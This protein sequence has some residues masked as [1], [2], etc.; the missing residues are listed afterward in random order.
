MNLRKVLCAGVLFA[1]LAGTTYADLQNVDVG[2][3]LRIRARYWNNTYVNGPAGP[4]EI[5]IPDFFVPRRP[6]GPFGVSSRYDWSSDEPD[7]QIVEQ[8]T[9]LDVDADFTNEVR[10]FIELE[11]YDW[12]GEEFRSD[13]VTGSDA[14]AAT[15]NDVEIYQAYIEASEMFGN[16]IRLRIGRQE[17]KLGKGWLVDDITTAIIGRSFDAIRITYSTDVVVVDAWYSKYVERGIAEQDGDV[18]FMGVYATCSA[19]E[20]LN[21]SLYWMWLRDG[22]SLNDTNV[23]AP[24]EWLEDLFNLDDYD[25]TNMYTVG[26]RLWGEAGALDYDLELAYQFGDAD[27]VGFGFK[28]VGRIYGDDGAEYDAWAADLEFGYI[29][30]MAWQPRVFIGGAYFE[31]Q[32]NRDLSFVDWINPFYRPE[33]SVSFNRMFPGKPY[34]LVLEIG[35]DMSNFYQVRTGVSVHPS[36]AVTAGLTVAYY[37]V[38]EPFDAPVSFAAGGFKIPLA[39]ALSFWTDESDDAIG[40]SAHGWIQYDYSED[41]YIKVGWE[42]LFTG[43]GLEDGSFSHLYGL[44][45]SGGRGD[46]DAD[47]V[48][49]DTGLKF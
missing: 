17:L 2:G 49:V 4:S 20:Y 13:Y 18:D 14:R 9:R 31:G 35:Q 16:P 1:A 30:D 36:E 47:Y 10:A 22:G 27:A 6:I 32:D 41:W 8:R 29:I 24:I 11:S 45:F 38:D 44:E 5:R 7:F 48:Y 19:L 23:I 43:E 26:A 37:G 33:A 28:P 46:D 25:A 39:P 42:H 21:T 15:T 12:W 34:S 3:E 40:T